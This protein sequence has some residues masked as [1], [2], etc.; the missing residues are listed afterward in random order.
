MTAKNQNHKSSPGMV[1]QQEREES[2]KP[3]HGAYA[4]SQE[5]NGFQPETSSSNKDFRSEFDLE[6]E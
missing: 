5:K 4:D 3:Q 1:E 6:L 2:R